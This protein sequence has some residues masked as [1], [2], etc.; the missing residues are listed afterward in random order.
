MQKKKMGIEISIII[1]GLKKKN[2]LQKGIKWGPEFV[3]KAVVNSFSLQMG[4]YWLKLV[5]NTVTETTPA[6]AALVEHPVIFE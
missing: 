5:A 1:R 6:A 2:N 4:K 3:W